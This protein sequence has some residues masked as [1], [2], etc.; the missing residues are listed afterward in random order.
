[1]KQVKSPS[2]AEYKVHHAA[3]PF[4]TG[5]IMQPVCWIGSLTLNTEC[6]PCR[7]N[8]YSLFAFTPSDRAA[9]SARVLTIKINSDNYL[10]CCSPLEF[11]RKK[12]KIW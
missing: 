11:Q 5:T 12:A 2:F 7:L 9:G 6:A 4:C 3:K 1:M 10:E 8:G